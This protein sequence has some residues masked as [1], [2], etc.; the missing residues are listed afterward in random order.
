MNL[1]HVGLIFRKDAVEILR[2]RRTLF[3]NVVLPVLLYPLLALFMLQVTQLSRLTPREP[4]GVVALDLPDDVL[5]DLDPEQREPPRRR[6]S[7]GSTPAEAVQD[8]PPV[9]RLVQLAPASQGEL[10]NLL[11]VQLRHEDAETA[12]QMA[13]RSEATSKTVPDPAL[14]TARA[15]TLRW[16]R[17]HGTAVVVWN[18]PPEGER[19]RVVVVRDDAHPRSNDLNQ[20]IKHAVEAWRKRL[21]EASALAVNLPLS[22]LDPVRSATWSCAPV[23]E[24]LRTGL[25]AILPML[26]VLMAASGAFF[27]AVDL[28]AGERERGTLETLL[29]WPADRRDLFLGKLLVACAAA[30]V[31]VGLNL[32][33]LGG[34][35]AMIAGGLGNAVT[36]PFAGVWSVGAGVLV[37]AFV[38]L[39]PITVALAAIALG[40]TGLAASTKEAQNYLTPLVLVVVVAAVPC[41]IP[42]TRPSIVLDLIPITGA[43]LVLK[44]GMLGNLSWLHLALAT[45][46]SAILATVVVAWAARLF[47]RES[48]R[49]PAM[50]RSGWGRFR[51]GG[52]APEGPDGLE[53][54]GIFAVGAGLFLGASTLLAQAHPVVALVVPLTLG[55]GLPALIFVWL[56]GWDR[57]IALH[58]R[59][60]DGRILVAAALAGVLAAAASVG[61]GLGQQGLFPPMD[62]AFEE[63]FIALQQAGPLVFFLSVTV[64]PGVCE[65]ILFRGVILAG[66][67]RSLGDATAV[68]ITAFL[69]AAMHMSPE[70]F[71][72]QF[73]VGLLLGALVVRCGS[74]WPAILLHALHNAAALGIG[75]LAMKTPIPGAMLA[76]A[77]LAGTVGAWTAM[78]AATRR[79]T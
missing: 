28:I 55:I 68:L 34:S 54:L 79:K 4:A 47:D 36:A 8:P 23:V 60:V 52:R 66:L 33:S 12:R 16:L 5:D 65:E 57:G 53:A 49:Y 77:A 31:T 1:H 58:A 15:T 44:E 14:A 46:S 73:L 20:P 64:V 76:L 2:D 30:A 70:R 71:I 11:H 27:P 67:R 61:I 41:L 10:T 21:T 56:G 26:L 25:A 9:L 75:T 32:L 78:W 72:P 3:V 39:L 62:K 45:A 59:R 13:A 19:R 6:K 38:V 42:D 63:K 35:A 50:A 7:A 69:F 18:A 74:I 43:A 37:L 17:A 51:R 22:A 48:F 40:A 24:T 29:T